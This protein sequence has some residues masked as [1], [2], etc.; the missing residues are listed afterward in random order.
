[1][2]AEM[3]NSHTFYLYFSKTV[4]H[5]RLI[6]IGAYAITDTLEF[7]TGGSVEDVAAS[8]AAAAQEKK[9]RRRRRKRATTQELLIVEGYIGIVEGYLHFSTLK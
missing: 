3:C 1:M 6:L 7:N 8:A 9:R 5:K 4:D 2:K